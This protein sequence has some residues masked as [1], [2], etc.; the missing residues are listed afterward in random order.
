MGTDRVDPF[1]DRGRHV[2]Q[3]CAMAGNA[4]LG[5]FARQC[6]RHEKP[7]GGDAI[8]LGAQFNDFHDLCHQTGPCAAIRNSTLP[9][10]P[11]IGLVVRPI[12]VQ[13]RSTNQTEIR[14]QTVR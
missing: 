11:A 1:Q 5:G 9:S 13:P 2:N 6:T 7:V 14:S 10:P 8:A 3:R 4:D 12:G